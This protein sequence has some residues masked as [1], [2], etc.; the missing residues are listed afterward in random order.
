MIDGTLRAAIK[1]NNVVLNVQATSHTDLTDRDVADQHPMSAITGL[2]D[3]LDA[4]ADTA[5]LSAVATSGD[6]D[7]LTNKPDLSVY[8][9][10]ADLAT[11]AI[12]GSYD[13]LADTPTIPTAVSQLTNDSG[14]L[15]LGTLPIWDGTVI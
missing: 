15:T 14:F 6:Y 7:D 13:D 5:D 11:V 12:S 3:A 4:K 9:E 10:S 8:A 1:Y 2:E